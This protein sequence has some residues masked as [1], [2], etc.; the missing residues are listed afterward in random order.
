MCDSRNGSR[1]TPYV[2]YRSRDLDL[3]GCHIIKILQMLKSSY[4]LYLWK[5]GTSKIF[6]LFTKE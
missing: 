6:G 3:V 2:T 1:V 5:K 4:C